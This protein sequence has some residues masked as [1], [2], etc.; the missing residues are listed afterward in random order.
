MHDWLF[1]AEYRFKIARRNESVS[2][3]VQIL[4]RHLQLKFSEKRFL[5]RANQPFREIYF[6]GIVEICNLYLICEA[7][8]RCHF[9]ENESCE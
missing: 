2:V 8:I 1:T 4:E 7:L 5:G 3:F 6:I 9:V